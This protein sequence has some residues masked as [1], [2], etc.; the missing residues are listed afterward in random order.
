MTDPSHM[1]SPRRSLALLAAMALACASITSGAPSSRAWAQP[2]TPPLQAP[3]PGAPRAHQEVSGEV[4]VIL[5]SE[6]VGTIHP[7]LATIPALRQPPFNGYHTMELLARPAIRLVVGEPQ[8]VPLPNGRVL[9]LELEGITREGR[10]RVRV[11][12][13]RPDQ[14][15]YLPLLDIVAPPGDPFFLAGQNFM[16]GTL[17]LGVRLGER[18]A[19]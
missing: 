7:D 13:N 15:D 8:T 10:Y 18:A 17:V 4:L 1:A 6:R 11:S 2:T 12:I 19:R 16:G 5:A 9:R 3:G 14:Q